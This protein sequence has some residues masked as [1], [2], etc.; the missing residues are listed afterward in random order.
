MGSLSLSSAVKDISDF[1][2]QIFLAFDG[3][4]ASHI[5]HPEMSSNIVQVCWAILRC[6]CCYMIGC[7]GSMNACTVYQS[8]LENNTSFA[9]RLNLVADQFVRQVQ[10]PELRILMLQ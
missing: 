7:F 1:V 2:H 3:P 4:L 9:W 8:V 6:T 10:H 5:I